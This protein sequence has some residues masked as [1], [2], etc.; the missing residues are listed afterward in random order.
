MSD[1]YQKILE[2][3]SDECNTS[4]LKIKNLV[5]KDDYNV[6]ISNV[7]DFYANYCYGIAS[8]NFIEWNSPPHY[9]FAEA[10][11][12]ILP[13]ITE[14]H[15]KFNN[16]SFDEEEDSNGDLVYRKDRMITELVKCHQLSIENLIELREGDGELICAVLE[17]DMWEE[18]DSF[19][20]KLRFQFPYCHIPKKILKK[21]FREELL[22][23]IYKSNISKYFTSCLP[24]GNWENYLQPVKEYYEMY[25]SSL[26]NPPELLLNVYG[27]LR[28]DN[29]MLL[30]L[31]KVF[32]IEN[33]H[34]I[35]SHRCD[36]ERIT[37]LTDEYDCEDEHDYC[38]DMVPV[39]LSLYYW[40]GMSKLKDSAPTRTISEEYNAENE[41]DPENEDEEEIQE[42]KNFEPFEICKCLIPMLSEKRFKEEAYFRD[43]LKAVYNATYGADEGLEYIVKLSNKADISYEKCNEIWEDLEVNE[44]V[45]DVTCETIAWY[46]MLDNKKK[47]EEWHERWCRIKYIEALDN[48]DV[49][50]AEA[51]YRTYWLKYKFDGHRWYEFRRVNH[52]LV[53]LSNDLIIES[54]IC[55]EF[56]DYFEKV[57][58]SLVTEKAKLQKKGKIKKDKLIFMDK[59][60]NDCNTVI[61][62]L[63]KDITI[64]K[65]IKRSK[66]YFYKEGMTEIIDKNPYV[67][68]CPN[69]VI[70]LTD[71]KAF[72]RDGKPEDYI[73]KSTGVKY[74]H[75][76]NYKNKDIKDLMLYLR[77]VFPDKDLLHYM[78][79]DFSALMYG[80]N[81]EK[82][83]RMW[84]GTTNGSKSV[85]QKVLEKMFG[86]YSCI[87]PSGLYSDKQKG[88]GPSPEMAQ[89]KNSRVGFSSEPDED[90]A[91]KG[92]RIK[93][94]AGGDAEFARECN[95][96]GGKMEM[97]YKTIMALNGVPHID[98]LD[99]ATKMRIVFQPFLGR[100]ISKDKEPKEYHSLP[101]DI[102]EQIKLRKYK[103]D[104]RFEN[105]VP[106]LAT[107][108]LWLCV[109]YYEV[110]CKE[111]L[112]AP[113][114]ISEY[115]E[116]Y[117]KEN[118]P[119]LFFILENLENAKLA[120]GTVDMKKYITVTQ[121]YSKFKSWFTATYPHDKPV[122]KTNFADKMST[123]DRLGKK[124]KNRWYGY[125][126]REF[127]PN[128]LDDMDE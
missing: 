57:R 123:K 34:F 122:D 42:Q 48:Y 103:M 81:A 83:F 50:I 74:R 1:F 2:V 92:S 63:K 6:D 118:D 126:I 13:I 109:Q 7:L 121:L 66:P 75:A 73:T 46:A 23:N 32:N 87:I 65:I 124:E 21:R 96:N 82:T 91:F 44:A 77:Q 105:Q 89:L 95:S 71:T 43:I 76:F 40:D 117:W 19:D 56:T 9:S 127:K 3:I 90:A 49:P 84:I 25:G 104:P 37:I 64:R 101:D 112:I 106:R 36:A 28:D 111:G 78:K 52:R 94:I 15:F 30:E 116:G 93:K 24:S 22:H 38:I 107:A 125:Q 53:Q 51:F 114:I 85:L 26:D 39:F 11:K 98:G 54:V 99:E 70:Q 97:T 29:E 14:F 60:I 100:W 67:L 69:C 110:Y 79:K 86:S 33:F 12:E 128:N 55:G 120:D 10:S 58:S 18:K 68:G 115:M 59:Q 61:N 4:V 88:S 72:P 80:R 47:Y 41:S 27:D 8:K 16:D 17:S 113:S 102:E 62:N 31:E 20:V 35:K 108:L 45:D 5:S 119:Y